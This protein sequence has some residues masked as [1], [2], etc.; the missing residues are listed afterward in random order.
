MGQRRRMT[1]H[2]RLL[3]FAGLSRSSFTVANSRL[4]QTK[5]TTMSPDCFIDWILVRTLCCFLMN[6]RSW[7]SD[8]LHNE[9]CSDSYINIKLLD[10]VFSYIYPQQSRYN[11]ECDWIMLMNDCMVAKE[12]RCIWH[13]FFNCSYWQIRSECWL[14]NKFPLRDNKNMFDLR[15]LYTVNSRV[16]GGVKISSVWTSLCSFFTK[17]Q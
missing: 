8:S 11:N 5:F 6:C 13:S 2:L 4:G 17:V 16:C 10:L 15:L 14:Y 1:E 3:N 7:K 12:M 9:L